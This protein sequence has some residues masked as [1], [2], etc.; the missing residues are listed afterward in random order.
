ML[1]AFQDE[2]VTYVTIR[3]EG[4]FPVV[5]KPRSRPIVA[6]DVIK[7]IERFPRLFCGR[8]VLESIYGLRRNPLRQTRS[9]SAPPFGKCGGDEPLTAEEEG[10]DR[11]GRV[12]MFVPW[13]PVS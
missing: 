12:L 11:G 7:R 1:L 13:H 6:R 3:R 10:G 8:G 9:L 5:R 4:D 2:H